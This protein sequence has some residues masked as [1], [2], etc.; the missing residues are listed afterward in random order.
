L[1]GALEKTIHNEFPE[2]F[3]QVTWEVTEEAASQLK[4]LSALTSEVVYFAAR[5]AIRN[6][7][8]HG[9]AGDLRPSLKI[10]TNQKPQAWEIL[11]ENDSYENP[12][13]SPRKISGGQGLALHST[14]MTI[15]GG[16]LSFEQLSGSIARV[17]LYVPSETNN[18]TQN[19]KSK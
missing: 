17:V 8:H 3:E 2:A 1:I 10:G 11:I 14:L 15:I 18:L 9:R 12:D 16:E 5:E 19:S 6:A 7:A 13:I 4:Q